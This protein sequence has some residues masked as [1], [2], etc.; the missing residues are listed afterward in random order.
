MEQVLEALAY[1]HQEKIIH[2]DLKP[3]NLILDKRE[4]I[5]KMID[6]GSAKEIGTENLVAQGDGS[7]EFLPPEIISGRPVGSYTDIWA[8]GMILY[9]SLR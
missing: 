6:L 8:F 5:V 9:A 2:L 4:N 1:L 3:E 7:L